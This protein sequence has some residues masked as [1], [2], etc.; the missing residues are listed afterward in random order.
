M[1]RGLPAIPFNLS[2]AGACVAVA[3]GKHHAVGID[4]ESVA[5]ED[6]GE[7]VDDVLTGRER[8]GLIRLG[9]ERRWEGFMRLWTVK[10]ASAKALGLGVSL[11]F[12][13]IEV[14]LDPLRVSV[15]SALPEM[16]GVK[17]DAASGTIA[18]EGRPYRL[19][20]AVLTAPA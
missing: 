20:I 8:E 15:S 4:V 16:R 11:D 13:A 12:R 9:R 19:S 17:L 7:L 1:E 10:E 18:C 3:I 2:H 5:A 14:D 6:R